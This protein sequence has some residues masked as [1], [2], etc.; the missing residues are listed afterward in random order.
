MLFLFLLY[1]REKMWG[2]K[3]SYRLKTTVRPVHIFCFSVVQVQRI[4]WYLGGQTTQYV[5]SCTCKRKRNHCMHDIFFCL[6]P[7]PA[8][9]LRWSDCQPLLVEPGD[10]AVA[11][12]RKRAFTKMNTSFQGGL[13]CQGQWGYLRFT[14]SSVISQKRRRQRTDD[15]Q[16]HK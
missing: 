9:I 16:A 8:G 12:F 2:K 14:T 13:H 7:H 3:S 10:I 1:F 11:A 5:T 4:A 6:C 15:I